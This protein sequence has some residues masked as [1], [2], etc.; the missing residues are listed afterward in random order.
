MPRM[1]PL[2]P[3]GPD[4]T[5][6]LL[7]IVL[8]ILLVGGSLWVLRPFIPAIVWATMIVVS[9]WGLMRAVERHVRRRR[10]DAGASRR[11]G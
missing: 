10:A 7:I 2:F 11:G 5:R 1:K 4:L 3:A 6:D 8:L 9:T